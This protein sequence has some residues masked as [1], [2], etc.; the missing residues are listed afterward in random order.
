MGGLSKLL[1]PSRKKDSLARAVPPARRRLK[2][3]TVARRQQQLGDSA[4]FDREHLVRETAEWGVFAWH[5]GKTPDEVRAIYGN[6]ARSYH[7]L[8][9]ALDFKL[10]VEM[11]CSVSGRHV[12]D[13]EAEQGI[14]RPRQQYRLASE[15]IRLRRGNRAA[16]RGASRQ[17]LESDD[18]IVPSKM[19]HDEICHAPRASELRQSRKDCRACHGQALLFPLG[20]QPLGGRHDVPGR[21]CGDAAPRP[22]QEVL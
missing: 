8:M 14:P 16:R 17:R 5:A 9:Q 19:E 13:V 4:W 11:L 10:P 15:A 22:S 20:I 3:E 6:A 21:A 2:P 12:E 7:D 18:P 1:T